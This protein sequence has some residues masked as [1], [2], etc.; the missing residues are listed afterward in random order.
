MEWAGICGVDIVEGE[1]PRN[2][3]INVGDQLQLLFQVND[4]RSVE[5]R[6]YKGNW[7]KKNMT[8]IYRA[9]VIKNGIDTKIDM[10][11]Q[12]IIESQEM[13]WECK[14]AQLLWKTL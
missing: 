12:N 6:Q 3:W 2:I 4:W 10:Y 7:T 14:L 9:I 5:M 8:S 13:W 11:Q 1:S